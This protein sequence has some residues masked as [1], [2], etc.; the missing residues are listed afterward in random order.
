MSDRATLKTFFEQGDF[1]TEAQF[2]D[3]IDSVVNILDD[4]PP[5]N[6]KTTI[7]T[8]QVKALFATEIPVIPAQGANT[9][10]N[11]LSIVDT[12]DFNTTAYTVPGLSR[13]EFHE[14]NLAGALI[15]NNQAGFVPS[16]STTDEKTVFSGLFTTMSR[17]VDIVA[18]YTV[19]NPTLGDSPIVVNA[20]AQVLT[21]P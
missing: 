10:V 17:N 1:P 19:G 18:A 8:A 9:I 4:V 2:A 16:G 20:L 6:F 12:L 3:F 13:L 5:V 7:T 14:T 11:I 15:A 21:V